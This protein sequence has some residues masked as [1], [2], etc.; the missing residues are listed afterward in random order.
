M[1]SKS[2][3]L[4]L[5]FEQPDGSVWNEILSFAEEWNRTKENKFTTGVPFEL[6]IYFPGEGDKELRELEH[7]LDQKREERQWEWIKTITNNPTKEE[8]EAHDY[9]QIIGDGYPDSFFMNESEALAP[10]EPCETCGT[11]HPHLR[12]Q[13]KPVQVNE[14]FLS[15]KGPPND[16]YIPE[17]L[18]IINLPHGALL[19]SKRVVELIKDKKIDG[20]TF[21]DVIDQKGNVSDRLFQLVADK[22][23]LLPDN[24]REEGAVCPTCGTVLSTMTTVFAIRKDRLE[25][26]SFFS[27]SPSGI[28]SLYISKSLYHFLKS[29]NTR[30]LT[31]VQGADVIN[32]QR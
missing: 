2:E 9:I 19:V 25:K 22:V 15:R 8:I 12:T 30:G 29:E 4:L 17:G 32:D 14:A 3:I 6:A 18:D 20:C 10:M 31:P 1:D 24:L 23:I 16:R 13:K 7:I 11:L 21:L 27:R 28:A 26:N 5:Q